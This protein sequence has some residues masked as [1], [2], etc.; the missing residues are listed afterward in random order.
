MYLS[1]DEALYGVGEHDNTGKEEP[2][3]IC[4]WINLAVIIEEITCKETNEPT[5]GSTVFTISMCIVLLKYA[6]ET[7]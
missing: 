7:S 6:Q 2:S 4:N 1:G 5:L 3:G